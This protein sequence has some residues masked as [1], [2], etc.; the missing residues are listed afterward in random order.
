MESQ[1]NEAAQNHSCILL[2]TS[3]QKCPGPVSAIPW[4]FRKKKCTYCIYLICCTS[5]H[6]APVLQLFNYVLIYQTKYTVSDRHVTRHGPPFTLHKSSVQWHHDCTSSKPWTIWL[7]ISNSS[8]I[9]TMTSS[10][11]KHVI[12]IDSDWSINCETGPGPHHPSAFALSPSDRNFQKWPKALSSLTANWLGEVSQWT[13]SI[14]IPPDVWPG[15]LAGV[16]HS[17][18]LR[19]SLSRIGASLTTLMCFTMTLELD[20]CGPISGRS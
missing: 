1:I 9:D 14:C 17:P 4:S 13:V 11:L 15:L 8:V 5:I 2:K 16:C 7:D 20:G 3:K 19:P 6:F 18:T 12:P 10:F